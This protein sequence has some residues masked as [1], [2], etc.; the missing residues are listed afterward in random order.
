MKST[1]SETHIHDLAIIGLGPVGLEAASASNARGLD[2]IGFEA[3]KV[4]GHVDQWGQVRLFSPF[5]LNAGPAGEQVLINA[6]QTL[7]ESD[8]IM[9]G[10]AFL[11]NYL[12]PLAD[13]LSERMDL[14][15]GSLLYTS[16][17]PRD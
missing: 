2:V 4:G 17:S 13:Q 15:E 1:A 9:T 6:E 14:L 3:T 12:R 8:E 16:P 11:N 7:P 5:E 10:A